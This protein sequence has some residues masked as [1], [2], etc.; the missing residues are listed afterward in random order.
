MSLLLY[1]ST[2]STGLPRSFLSLLLPIS[3]LISCWDPM[4]DLKRSI[5][6]LKRS[7]SITVYHFVVMLVPVLWVLPH[8]TPRRFLNASDH[9]F[10]LPIRH[11]CIGCNRLSFNSPLFDKFDQRS[12]REATFVIAYSQSWYSARVKQFLFHEIDHCLPCCVFR[13][14]NNRPVRKMLHTNQQQP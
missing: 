11:W 10:G 3:L 7:T 2:T 14:S 13:R 4:Q 12:C 8:Q 6:A 1:N 9:S 5:P